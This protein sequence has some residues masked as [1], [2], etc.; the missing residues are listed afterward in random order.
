MKQMIHR[1]GV[2]V[3]LTE[4]SDEALVLAMLEI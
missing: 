1:E 2:S 4:S 3:S